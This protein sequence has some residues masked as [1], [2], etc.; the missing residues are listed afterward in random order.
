MK[1]NYEF[2]IDTDETAETTA[3]EATKIKEGGV[4]GADAAKTA[5][6]TPLAISDFKLGT[7][8]IIIEDR[9]QKD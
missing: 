5:S 4:E 7:N 1:I 8:E 9:K 2:V 6:G 3:L